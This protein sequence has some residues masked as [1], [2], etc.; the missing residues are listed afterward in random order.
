MENWKI[1]KNGLNMCSF[2]NKE[3]E[4]RVTL[5]YDYNIGGFRELSPYVMCKNYLY[6]NRCY[7]R[8][9]YGNRTRYYRIL[10]TI[11]I[12]VYKKAMAMF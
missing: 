12:D 3:T 8:D 9:L 4:T 6:K 7:D 10:S 2:Y 11:P 5:E 1:Y